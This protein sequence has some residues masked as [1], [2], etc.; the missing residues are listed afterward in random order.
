MSFVTVLEQDAIDILKA[1][2]HAIE[3]FAIS[4]TQKLVAQA[5]TTP[6]GTLAL[7]LVGVFES[8]DMSGEAKMAS[9]VAALVPAITALVAGGGL[10]GLGVSIAD[11][12]LEFA[13]S[14][15][16]DA[17]AALAKVAAQH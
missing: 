6:L 7:N 9:V 1:A 8:H 5:K 3:A 4:E 17:A 16:N 15:F 12:A 10:P 14:S 13:Q 11:F 2:G